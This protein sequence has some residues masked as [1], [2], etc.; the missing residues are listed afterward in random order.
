MTDQCTQHRGEPANLCG[1]CRTDAIVTGDRSAVLAWHQSSQAAKL[2]EAI[3]ERYRDA[4]AD[5]PDVLAWLNRWHADPAGCP[6]LLLFGPVG[7]GKTW[8]AYG[9]LKAAVS[10]RRAVRTVEA[11]LREWRSTTWIS[12][13][14]A[15]MFAALRPAPKRDTEAELAKFRDVDLL[16]VDD[17]GASKGSEWVEETTYRIIGG[18]Y[19]A[20]RPA[21][22]TTNLAPGDV[23]DA[24][25][26]RITSRLVE[27]CTRV[28]LDGPDRRRST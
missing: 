25:G 26:D 12:T 20:M 23:K 16:L 28:V 7:T 10:G 8:Q 15:D 11:S 5:H 27:T 22:Y 14:S 4:T 17:L 1:P 9:V 3:P 21:I 6:S 24:L 18:R 19:D 13:T 2:V